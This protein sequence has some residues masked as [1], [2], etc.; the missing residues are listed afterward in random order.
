MA[1]ARWRASRPTQKWSTFASPFG[2][3]SLRS[4]EVVAGGP[5]AE[6]IRA[7]MQAMPDLPPETLFLYEPVANARPYQRRGC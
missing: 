7:V 5:P 1:A 4:C 6:T 2:R 3:T